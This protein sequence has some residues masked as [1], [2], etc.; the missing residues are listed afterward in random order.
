MI[1][2]LD[3]IFIFYLWVRHLS[4]QISKSCGILFKIQIHLGLHAY[5]LSRGLKL[6]SEAQ[7]TIA[8]YFM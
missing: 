6:A 3:I 2:D 7:G 1:Q 8:L 5:G 4:R